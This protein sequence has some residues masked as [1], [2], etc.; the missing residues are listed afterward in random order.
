MIYLLNRN[1]SIRNVNDHCESSVSFR[2]YS[3]VALI[4]CSPAPDRVNVLR[5]NID[6]YIALGFYVILF[7][8]EGTDPNNFIENME[9]ANVSE[10]ISYVL[11]GTH[12]SIEQSAG[13]ARVSAFLF[14]YNY[15]C[16]DNAMI[17][18]GDDR[19]LLK[20]TKV[21]LL[22]V[23]QEIQSS[24]I[25]FP[26]SQRSST[27]GK[28]KTFG[29]KKPKSETLYCIEKLGQI[30]ICSYRAIQKICT[31][32]LLLLCMSAPIFEDYVLLTF[33]DYISIAISKYC[34][35]FTKNPKGVKTIARKVPTYEYLEHLF[36]RQTS[37]S[38]FLSLVLDRIMQI[39]YSFM[40]GEGFEAQ[41][42]YLNYY[43]ILSLTASNESVT[44]NWTSG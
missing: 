23:Y 3:K 5:R 31:N 8:H 9:L 44:S 40:K 30:Y 33:K 12:E 19:R 20:T 34:S 1:Y 17:V 2:H 41:L 21:Q 25:V 7:F 24:N 6:N 29:K 18:I 43:E 15:L 37:K 32:D 36:S 13:V 11:Y 4:I 28:R 22:N 38:Y 14:A 27:C 42:A 10:K 35:R 16:A 39:N 26:Q